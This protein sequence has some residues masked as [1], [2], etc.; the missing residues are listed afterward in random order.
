MPNSTY[1]VSLSGGGVSISANAKRTGDGSIGVEPT[2]AVA[3]ALSSWVKTDANTA[4]GN[5]TTGHG[6]TTGTYDVYWTG[7]AR[8]DVAATITVDAVALDGGSGTDFPANGNTTVVLA[9]QTPF[10]V[11]IDGDNLSIVGIKLHYDSTSVASAGRVLFEDAANDDI[12]DLELV[13]NVPQVWDVYGGSA[14]PFAGDPITHG[15]AS[16]ANTS[17]VPKL[18]ICGAVDATP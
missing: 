11:S 10:N 18:K 3:K 1:N 5:L 2:L 13:G 17:S 6:L 12:L 7:G 8:F 16:H 4:A 9:P 15:K 14:N